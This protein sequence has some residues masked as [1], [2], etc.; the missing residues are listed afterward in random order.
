MLG[1]G[2]VLRG[3]KEMG[4]DRMFIVSGIDY[5]A[6]IEEKVRNKEDAPDFIVVPH[7]ITAT[8]AA[9]GYSM[10]EKLGVVAVHT[11]PGTANAVGIIANAF[12]ARRPLL[13]IAGGSPYT[14]EGHPASRSFRISVGTRDSGPRRSCKTDSEVGLRGEEN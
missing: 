1:A 4:V 5:P 11:T 13:V 6:F 7:E 10:A 14:E 2:V 12:Y 3:L 8:S 9:M